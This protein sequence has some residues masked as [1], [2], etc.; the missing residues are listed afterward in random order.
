MRLS[1][2]RKTDSL[3]ASNPRSTMTDAAL[4]EPTSTPARFARHALLYGAAA[5]AIG[6]GMMLADY[7]LGF[8][9]E[10]AHIGR[11]TYL[12]GLV[13]PIAAVV[14]GMTSWRNH[15]LGGRIRFAQAFGMALAIGL[16]FA[17]VMG[18]TAWWQTAQLAPDLIHQRIDQQAIAAA[19]RPDANPEEI[20][21][22][23][24]LAKASATPRT[25]AKMMFTMALVHAFFVGLVAA[26]TVPKKRPG[27]E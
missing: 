9:T 26:I 22:Q 27:L 10:R 4:L 13:I 19:Q 17:I 15:V 2:G 25:Y 6:G 11:W 8:Q 20:A 5:G 14:L 23:V 1:H 21:R 18:L 12:L 3:P 7:A 24:E 16:V